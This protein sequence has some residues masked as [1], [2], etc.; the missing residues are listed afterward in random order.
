MSRPELSIVIPSYNMAPWLPYAV[1][2]C[3]WQSEERVEVV[4]INDGSHDDTPRIADLYA[5]ADGRVRVHHQENMGLGRTRQVGQEL[6]R[7]RFMM[8]LDADDF[9]DSHG[10]RDM[11]AVADRDKVNLVCGNAVVFSDHSF[12]T[13]HYF[14]HP[15][16]S[17][18]TFANPRYWKSK[19]VWRWIINTDFINGEGIVHPTYKLG[20]DVIVMYDL[21]TRVGHFSQCPSSFYYFRQEHK[22]VDSSLATEI[23]HQLAHYTAVRAVLERAGQTRPLLKYLSENYVRDIR[24]IMPRILDS[25]PQWVERVEALGRELFAGMP[26]EWLA[27]AAYAPELRHSP[28]LEALGRAFISGDGAA[29]RAELSKYGGRVAPPV[30]KTRG[31]HDL[32]RRIKALCYPLSIGARRRHAQLAARAAKRLGEEWS[33]AR[34]P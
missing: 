26:P 33:P 28:E 10:A 25:E 16:A 20:Q 18:T 19:V 30:D 2:S 34:K 21:L 9:L 8:W 27:P 4:I 23:E 7:G 12:N 22:K 15:A 32:R 29:I 11:L 6:A 31:W 24:C 5:R 17:R 1:E 3:L 13:R 14:P